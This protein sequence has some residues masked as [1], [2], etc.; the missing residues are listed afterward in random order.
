MGRTAREGRSRE[1]MGPRP[2]LRKEEQKLA[3]PP[4]CP[5]GEH[6]KHRKIQEDS[7][8]SLE[9][10]WCSPLGLVTYVIITGFAMNWLWL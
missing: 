2:A 10:P 7:E 4:F 6:S 1:V 9:T 5:P 3:L 8:D